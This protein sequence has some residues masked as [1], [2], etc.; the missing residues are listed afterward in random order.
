MPFGALTLNTATYNPR[1]DGVYVLSTVTFG[2]PSNELRIYPALKPD[3]NG[4]LRATIVRVTEK[5][6]AEDKRFPALVTVSVA[7]PDNGLFTAADVDGMLD[8]ISDFVTTDTI[9]RVLQGEA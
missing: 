8:D 9:T 3:K 5:E 6:D 2:D 1:K 4:A 7:I